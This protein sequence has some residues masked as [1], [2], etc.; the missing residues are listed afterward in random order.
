[1]NLDKIAAPTN[2]NLI[3]LFHHVKHDYYPKSW[4]FKDSNKMLNDL[5]GWEKSMTT[6][7]YNYYLDSNNTFKPDVLAIV[8][9]K[10][11][12]SNEFRVSR[13]LFP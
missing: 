10:F 7:I 3:Y 12:S 13:D 1:M 2:S 6:E 8:S 11:I 5:G 4:V 9:K